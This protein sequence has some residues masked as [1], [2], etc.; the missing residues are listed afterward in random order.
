MLDDAL[1]GIYNK[2]RD[3][4]RRRTAKKAVREKVYQHRRA[5]A[6]LAEC[7]AANPGLMQTGTW[8]RRSNGC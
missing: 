5:M 4:S 8:L 1:Q 7:D 3:R 6:T 2:R